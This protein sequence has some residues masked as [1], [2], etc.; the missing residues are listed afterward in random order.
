MDNERQALARA[1]FTLDMPPV[2]GTILIYTAWHDAPHL[3]A[4]YLSA[5]AAVIAKTQPFGV[6]PESAEDLAANTREIWRPIV[7]GVSTIAEPTETAATERDTGNTA[8]RV[9]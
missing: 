6:A 7:H 3:H 8:T 9:A 5:A 4:Q 1:I 2:P